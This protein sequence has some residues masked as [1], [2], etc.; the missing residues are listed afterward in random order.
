VS[1]L[2]PSSSSAAACRTVWLGESDLLRDGLL[3]D[4]KGL[5]GARS[6]VR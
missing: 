3:S 4:V 5:R 1:A 6:R 2:A